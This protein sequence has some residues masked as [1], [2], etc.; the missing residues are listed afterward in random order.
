MP[1]NW[2]VRSLYRLGVYA[3]LK[4]RWMADLA[5]ARSQIRRQAAK[6][7][8]RL[9]EVSKNVEAQ[10]TTVA[11]MKNRIEALELMRANDEQQHLLSRLPMLLDREEISAHVMASVS[12][13]RVNATPMSHA[14]VTELFP[15]DFY[16]LLIQTLPAAVFF[17]DPQNIKLNLTPESIGPT[18]SKQVWSFMETEVTN[19]VLAPALAEKF[20][21]YLKPYC[22]QEFGP[23]LGEKVADLPLATSANRIMLRRA[24]YHV[25]PHRDPKRAFLTCLIYLAR[26]GD[27]DSW[28]TQLF[29][30]DE[31]PASTNTNDARTPRPNRTYYPELE[32]LRCQ[33]VSTV[34]FRENS[35]VVFVNTGG[36]H[37]ADIP[38]SEGVKTLRYAYQFYIGPQLAELRSLLSR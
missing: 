32:G 12:R 10:T 21:A 11:S 3:H 17:G 36:A 18:V 29:K 35:A 25:A 23:V 22:R 14:V 7:E 28:G 24:G 6:R 31:P 19:Q 37:G 1:P 4:D 5:A 15:P 2:I 9:K 16:H 26:P 30:V 20:Q 13:S 34:P 33:L 27:S 8:D 38:A